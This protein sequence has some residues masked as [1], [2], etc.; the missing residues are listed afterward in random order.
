MTSILKM[1]SGKPGSS[2]LEAWQVKEFLTEIENQ[3]L[4][5][6]HIVLSDIYDLQPN[7]YSEKG[8][9]KRRI[10][11]KQWDIYK[12]YDIKTYFKL[13]QHYEVTPSNHTTRTYQSEAVETPGRDAT[14]KENNASTGNVDDDA[15]MVDSKTA[16]K[17]FSSPSKKPVVASPK[18]HSSS[19]VGRNQ[20]IHSASLSMGSMN[21]VINSMVE[22]GSV[23]FDG[24]DFN[25]YVVNGS[26]LFYE[27][28]TDLKPY[29]VQVDLS[30][31]ERNREFNILRVSNLEHNECEYRAFHIRT[32]IAIQ[33][34]MKWK[35]SIP[36]KLPRHLRGYNERI[37][38]IEGPSQNFWLTNPDI[39]FDKVN[40]DA[41][42]TADLKINAR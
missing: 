23:G 9:D 17:L 5:Q 37:V 7:S 11:Q 32:V 39:Y 31:P 8:S 10:F 42:Q 14:D 30:F 38:W 29:T 24:Q 21:D 20:S 2:K 28:G 34:A 26:S 25:G 12:N 22:D 6:Q 36:R 1:P 18:F 27:D 4:P 16:S 3:N 33:D 41:T 35:A 15:F 13:L 19:S 40:C